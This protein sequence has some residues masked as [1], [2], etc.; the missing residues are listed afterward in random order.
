[1]FNFFIVI[2]E[3]VPFCV[4]SVLLVCKCVLYVVLLPPGV[5][6]IAVKYIYITII[7]LPCSKDPGSCPSPER[8]KCSPLLL[9]CFLKIN[10]SIFLPSSPVVSNWSFFLRYPYQ[11]LFAY[12][13]PPYV[14]RAYCLHETANVRNFKSHCCL[15]S[16]DLHLKP[17]ADFHEI[18]Y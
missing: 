7:S 8:D 14:Q 11:H 15:Y 4:F 6:P 18:S 3:Y 13:F 1:M 16:Y 5:N 12:L 10:F 17:L 2:Y 9:L